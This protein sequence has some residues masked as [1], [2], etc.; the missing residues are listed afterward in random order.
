M[1]SGKN[2]L[3]ALLL[4]LL[5]TLGLLCGGLWYI[6]S[7]LFGRPT[8]QPPVAQTSDQA[9][10]AN[11]AASPT[12]PITA[13]PTAISPAAGNPAANLNTS[14]PNPSV[15]GI[16]GSVTLVALVKQLQTAYLQI[17]PSLPTTYGVPDGKPNGTNSGIQN[18]LNGQVALAVSSRPLK[19]EELQAGL[20]AVPIARDALAVAVGVENP[21]QGGLTLDQLKQIFQ[22]KITNWS[23][24]GGPDLPIRV[25]NRAADSGTRTFFQDVVL[26][27]EAFAPDGG[28]ITT[29]ERDETTPLLRALGRDSITY[30]S[31]T[32]TENQQT[33]RTLLIDGL[34]P[35]DQTAVKTGTY[36]ISRVTYL[37]V[38]QQTSLAVK[39]FID[40]TLSPVGQ[41]IV[42]RLGFTP[43]Q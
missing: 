32:Q 26:L 20:Q 19:P 14:L 31:V 39:Q 34:A 18:L 8:G 40:L 29:A 13:S 28:N 37:V 5:I 7:R 9:S 30:S 15:L 3:P 38:P 42:Q 22:G 2:D 43:I 23:Q 33:V 1:T 4:T 6:G 25:I 10:P 11:P 16:D 21:Y 17:N 35:T 41:Q 12:A 24:V 27:G 36:P